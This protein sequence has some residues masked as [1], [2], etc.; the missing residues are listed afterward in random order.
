MATC[1]DNCTVQPSTSGTDENSVGI[2][3]NHNSRFNGYTEICNWYCTHVHAISFQHLNVNLVICLRIQP[4]IRQTKLDIFQ[5]Q[6]GVQTL[7]TSLELAC[8]GKQHCSLATP[9]TLYELHKIYLPQNFPPAVPLCLKLND[10]HTSSEI[11]CCT[12]LRW[13]G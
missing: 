10:L 3:D 11:C 2:Q 13:T 5:V 12:S 9:N 4:R 7:M 6:T 1:D 8:M